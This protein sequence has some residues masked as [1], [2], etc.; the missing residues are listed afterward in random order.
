MT[1]KCLVDGEGR[2]SQEGN[3]RK[4][5]NQV[6]I[7]KQQVEVASE[8]V[9]K[10]E[11][12]WMNGTRTCQQVT[13]G[14]HRPAGGRVRIWELPVT[15]TP[16]SPMQEA[17]I[18]ALGRMPIPAEA[19]RVQAEAELVTGGSLSGSTVRTR[20]VELTRAGVVTLVDRK[21]RSMTGNRCSRYRLAWKG[22][23]L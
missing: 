2:K 5:T 10:T 7:R 14:T 3:R 12:S 19:W 6:D 4:C 11:G 20:L 23:D 16:M 21:G 13:G 15:G 22:G 8:V 17:V 1:G 18:M 9:V